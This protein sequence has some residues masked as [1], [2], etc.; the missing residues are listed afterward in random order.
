[1]VVKKFGK[2]LAGSRSMIEKGREGKE[3]KKEERERRERKRKAG[4]R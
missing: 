4:T 2:R 1:M 3:K